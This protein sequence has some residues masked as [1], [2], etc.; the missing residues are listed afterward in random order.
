MIQQRLEIAGRLRRLAATE[1]TVSIDGE[2]P[3]QETLLADKWVQTLL[4]AAA[5]IETEAYERAKK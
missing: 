4:D 3:H 1:C 2:P 5:I